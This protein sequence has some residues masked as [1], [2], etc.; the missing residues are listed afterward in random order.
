MLDFYPNNVLLSIGSINI[1]Y[2]GVIISLALIIGFFVFYKLAQKA[3]FKKDFIFNLLIFDSY[4]NLKS[5]RA[6]AV[7][8]E[9]R[10]IKNPLSRYLL[11]TPP[12]FSINFIHF[13]IDIPNNGC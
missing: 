7:K 6:G 9:D 1:Y 10:V 13:F 5:I 12:F 11:S 3:G 8:I 4:F 2:Y